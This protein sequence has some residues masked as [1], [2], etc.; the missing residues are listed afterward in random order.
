ML[1]HARNEVICWFKL[2]IVDFANCVTAEDPP[3]GDVPCPPHDPDGID[4][5]YL[6][7]LRSLRLYFQRIWKELND[8]NWLERGDLEGMTL[9]L[10]NGAGKDSK[11]YED[12]TFSSDD[13]GNVSF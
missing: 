6:R 5:G 8:A 10:N 9:Q 2:K 12:T 3:P 13:E 4:R 11:G 7:G 1:I